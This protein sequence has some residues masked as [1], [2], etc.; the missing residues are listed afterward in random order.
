MYLSS[1]TFALDIFN[2]RRRFHLALELVGIGRFYYNSTHFH[3]HSRT[4]TLSAASELLELD[5]IT[6]LFAPTSEEASFFLVILAQPSRYVVAVSAFI[7]KMCLPHSY[8]GAT[9][10]ALSITDKPLL[11]IYGLSHKHPP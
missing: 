11:V 1:S 7:L 3:F 4:Q 9:K 6:S 10:N 8:E 2:E 5:T